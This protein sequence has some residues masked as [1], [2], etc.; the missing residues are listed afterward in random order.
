MFTEE[1][2]QDF[3]VACTCDVCGA[4]IYVGDVYYEL[5]TGETV[6]DYGDCI[7]DWLD[8]YKRIGQPDY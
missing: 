4:L 3:N 2:K 6:C 5:P 1:Q 7:G 8:E